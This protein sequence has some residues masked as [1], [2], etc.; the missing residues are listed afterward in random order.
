MFSDGTPHSSSTTWR[1]S[2]AGANAVFPQ[3][4]GGLKLT[5]R[6]ECDFLSGTEARPDPRLRHAYLAGETESGWSLLAGQTYDAW[7]IRDVTMLAYLYP[8][9]RRPQLRLTKNAVLGDGTRLTA[10]LAAVENRGDSLDPSHADS[11][12]S[13]AGTL[14]E[15][16]VII[17]RSLLTEEPSNLSLGGAYGRERNEFPENP[18]ENGLYDVGFL[19][20]TAYIPICHRVVVS[21]AAYGGE[22][23][24]TFFLGDLAE[25][26]NPVSGVPIRSLGGWLQSTVR[27]TPKWRFNAGYVWLDPY[28]E[29]VGQKGCSRHACHFAN[30]AYR[31]TP[32][33]QGVAESN[34]FSKEEIGE[35]TNTYVRLQLSLYIFF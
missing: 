8:C 5:G 26:V 21:G 31:F 7:Y 6:I 34:F 9:N 24:D 2:R 29:D 3:P 28:D 22:N 33:I 23:V 12:R 13:L 32:R 15:P 30:T 14:L 10:R 18:S 19:M 1:S 16:A 27:V 35:N 25:G 17:E 11:N 4:A 20:A